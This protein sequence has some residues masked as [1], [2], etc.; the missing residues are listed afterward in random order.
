MWTGLY[1]YTSTASFGAGVQPDPWPSTIEAHFAVLGHQTIA[2][3]DSTRNASRV[4]LT[5]DLYTQTPKNRTQRSVYCSQPHLLSTLPVCC[6]SLQPASASVYFY[7]PV[8]QN[9]QLNTLSCAYFNTLTGIGEELELGSWGYKIG[10]TLKL[11]YRRISGPKKHQTTRYNNY[12]IK[13]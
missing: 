5:H 8:P 4:I 7:L 1:K 10:F 2:T 12:K 11:N 6:V 9:K 13:D 3:Q